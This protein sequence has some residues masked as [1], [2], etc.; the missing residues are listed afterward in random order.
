MEHMG[1]VSLLPPII[2][3]ILAIVT[4]N[5]VI[6]LFSGVYIGVLILVGGHPLEATMETIENY[7]FLQVAD[8]YN[9]AVLVLLF[10][11]GG[12]VALMEKSG[13]GAAL[14]EKAAKFI[15]TRVRAQLSAWLGGVIIFFSDIGTPLIVGP[16]FEKIFDK[17]KIS[18]EKLAWIIDSTSSP[19]AVLIPFIGWGVYIMGLIKSE[20]DLLNITTSEFS[21]L[22]QVIPFQFYAILAVLMVPL[23]AMTKL[24]FGPMAKAERRI[25]QTGALYWPESTPLRKPEE[26]DEMTKGSH[27]NLIILPLLVLFITL[28]GLL[29][30]LGFPFKPVPG[31]EFRVALSTAYLFAAVTIIILM[32][33]YKVKKFGEIFTIYTTGMQKMV[34][35][36]VTLV[37]AWSLGKVINE[38]GTANYIVE[39]MQG[40]VPAF[41]IPAILFLVG[42]G[43]SLASGTSWGTFAI[44]LPIAIP[45]AVTLDAHLL[46]CIG[47]VLSGGIFGDHCSP[48]SDTT[49]LSSTGAG[50]D[51][52]DHV[53]TQFPYALLNA[54]IAFVG[55]IV[56]GITGSAITLLLTVVLLLLAVLVL[57]KLNARK[58]KKGVAV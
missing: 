49:I 26:N 48:I 45:M 16:V 52:I 51:H 46:V 19:V 1:I 3:V 10:F 40:N 55:F 17:A 47:A 4:K 23:V 57:S 27:A 32:L 28:F 36:A 30:S 15:N 21:T 42:A 9:A 37:L 11:I 54:S 7:L 41:I 38:M 35:V 2:A 20:F 43:M 25:Q 8:G 33:I 18:R 13:G 12:F 31:N 5:V 56:A 58:Y 53:K 22:V 44:M 34:Y 6:S 14:A 24:D 50:A 39:V 29:I